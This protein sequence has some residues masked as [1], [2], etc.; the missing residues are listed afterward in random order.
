MLLSCGIAGGKWMIQLVAGFFLLKEKRWEFI[1]RIGL[2][3]FAGSVIL[4]PYCIS[5]V[6]KLSDSGSF[7]LGSLIFSVA[8]MIL[9]YYWS[10]RKC[11]ISLM[12]WA[13]WLACLALAISLQLTVVFHIL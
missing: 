8:S 13:A 1:R 11:Q 12:W 6:M 10:V 3:C 7:F 5:S 9:I 4:L 2:T